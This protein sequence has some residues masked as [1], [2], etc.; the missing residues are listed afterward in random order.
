MDNQ[1]TSTRHFTSRIPQRCIRRSSV[2][3]P[4]TPVRTVDLKGNSTKKNNKGKENRSF[5]AAGIINDEK[6]CIANKTNSTPAY[7]GDENNS[8]AARIKT[9]SAF[10][11]SKQKRMKEKGRNNE[12]NDKLGSPRLG[13]SWQESKEYCVNHRREKCSDCC[14]EEQVINTE[15]FNCNDEKEVG[16]SIPDVAVGSLFAK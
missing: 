12:I 16:N 10:R 4:I 5:N 6:E 14:D 1:K 8:V 13:Q 7:E 11:R 9:Y 15:I 3:N 2:R